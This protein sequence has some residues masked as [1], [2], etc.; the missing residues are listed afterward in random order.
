M[1]DPGPVAK[2]V[3]MAGD[4]TSKRLPLP[5]SRLALRKEAQ[6]TLEDLANRLDVHRSTV[7]RWERGTRA[8]TGALREKYVDLLAELKQVTDV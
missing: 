8:P 7:S 6:L 1:S 3:P 4:L 2:L 5:E